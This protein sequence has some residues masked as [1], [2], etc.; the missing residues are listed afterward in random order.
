ML[1]RVGG[2]GV[3]DDGV[4][5]DGDVDADLAEVAGGTGTVKA[6]W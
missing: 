4:G 6:K 5:G 1:L 2:G 3:D